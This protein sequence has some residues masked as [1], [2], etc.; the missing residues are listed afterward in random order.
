MTPQ[1]VTLF[2]TIEAEGHTEEYL[3]VGW[4]TSFGSYLPVGIRLGEGTQ[5]GAHVLHLTG[6]FVAKY[7]L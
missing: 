2:L 7:L 6:A 4:E 1:N 3:I 5:V